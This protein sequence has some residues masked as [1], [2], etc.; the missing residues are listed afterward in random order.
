MN[1][2]Y[3][4]WCMQELFEVESL[5]REK[6]S[7]KLEVTREP[8]DHP[9]YPF[10]CKININKCFDLVIGD[11]FCQDLFVLSSD[12]FIIHSSLEQRPQH[13]FD[14]G[15]SSRNLHSSCFPAT[16]LKVLRCQL[17]TQFLHGL[18]F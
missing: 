3:C 12:M 17:P 4:L 8:T 1:I 7:S 2:L 15:L 13:L 14:N 18:L 11:Q 6:L 16:P 5:R 10:W 9:R